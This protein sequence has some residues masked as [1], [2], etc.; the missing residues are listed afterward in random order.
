[1]FTNDCV[2]K[3]HYMLATTCRESDTETAEISESAWITKYLLFMYAA[4]NGITSGNNL[5]DT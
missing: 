1:M 2:G 3:E 4:D 5:F